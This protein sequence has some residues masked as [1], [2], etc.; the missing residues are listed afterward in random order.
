MSYDMPTSPSVVNPEIAKV[1]FTGVV[2]APVTAARRP[3]GDFAIPVSPKKAGNFA[4]VKAVGAFAAAGSAAG[5]KSAARRAPSMVSRAQ[6]EATRLGRPE[7]VPEDFV[8]NVA[9]PTRDQISASLRANNQ[10]LA[11]FAVPAAKEEDLDA[12]P[13]RHANAPRY[14]AL[15]GDRLAPLWTAKRR[16]MQGV[17]FVEG[18]EAVKP[19]TK[20]EMDAV[21]AAL[22]GA[23]KA[24]QDDAWEWANANV[25]GEGEDE[26][27]IDLD[28]ELPPMHIVLTNTGVG[29]SE[30]GS[31]RIRE[32]LMYRP[33]WPVRAIGGEDDGKVGWGHAPAVVAGPDYGLLGELERERLLATHDKQGQLLLTSRGDELEVAETGYY[34]GAERAGCRRMTERKIL[35]EAGL[36]SHKL[37]KQVVKEKETGEETV[38]ECPYAN[39]EEY[40]VCPVIAMRLRFSEDPLGRGFIVNG[41]LDKKDLDAEPGRLNNVPGVVLTPHAMS[42]KKGVPHNVKNPRYVVWDET[43]CGAMVAQTVMPMGALTM[44]RPAPKLTKK[45]RED[46]HQ[47]EFLLADRNNLGEA[48]T[49]ALLAGE[50]LADALMFYALVEDAWS[51]GYETITK[52]RRERRA[53]RQ[54]FDF[55]VVTAEQWDEVKRLLGT[56]KRVAWGAGNVDDL[57][58]HTLTENENEARIREIAA[59]PTAP[60]AHEEWRFY[61]ILE[62]RIEL[63]RKHHMLRNKIAALEGLAAAGNQHANVEQRLEKMKAKLAGEFRIA[64]ARD[65]RIALHPNGQDIELSWRN[66]FVWS[67]VPVLLLDASANR[68]LYEAVFGSK[69]RIVFHD[70]RTTE[71][72]RTVFVKHDACATGRLVE[73]QYD[74]VREVQV[75]DRDGNVVGTR[76]RDTKLEKANNRL[77]VKRAK[78]AIAKLHQGQAMLVTSTKKL[79]AEMETWADGDLDAVAAIERGL[80]DPFAVADVSQRFMHYGNLR[81]KDG[82][83]DFDVLVNVGKQELPDDVIRREARA[84]YYD[85][86]EEEGD[87]LPPRSAEEAG[88]PKTIVDRLHRMRDGRMVVIPTPI[89][90]NVWEAM[91]QEQKREEEISQALG[92]LRPFH[93]LVRGDHPSRWQVAYIIGNVA[94]V[95]IVLD[96]VISIDDLAA[97]TKLTEVAMTNGGVVSSRAWEAA[98]FVNARAKTREK[99]PETALN[100][101]I[102][103]AAKALRELGFGEDEQAT[104]PGWACVKVKSGK[105]GGGYAVFVDLGTVSEEDVCRAAVAHLAAFGIERPAEDAYVVRM[106]PLPNTPV[107]TFEDTRASRAERLEAVREAAEFVF[108][109]MT[110]ERD[111]FPAQ[112]ELF[113]H[114]RA[115]A[116]RAAAAPA[117]KRLPPRPPV[118]LG[119]DEKIEHDQAADRDERR[120]AFAQPDEVDEQIPW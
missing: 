36:S 69:F 111:E 39:H 33:L 31:R 67:K 117:P 52:M 116:T 38:Y 85:Q 35:A 108:C 2:A 17:R 10:R 60:Y 83:R 70:L 43:A 37:C 25:R 57:I 89:Y 118:G 114:Q 48:L 82:A 74:F 50:E 24:F 15:E 71:R 34:C 104:P 95:N 79:R 119:P 55:S 92:R 64:R 20:E 8:T 90:R 75:K 72:L 106:A 49:D 110:G 120:A 12:A 68:R 21:G 7:G 73:D 51:N 80:P 78:A 53:R 61:K 113:R 5:L 6:L 88:H 86:P 26:D 46:G 105:R 99:D 115:L 1:A 101:R 94:P 9:E 16:E 54:R 84:F 63:L 96:D 62:D 19:L 58:D 11:A 107:I 3:F 32:D 56:V 87:V 66:E 27:G 22:D 91:V 41:K 77:K 28:G 23:I 59:T 97:Q 18:G 14:E 30:R 13:S 45:E 76:V 44:V 65:V 103:A 98:G 47:A 109:E 81:G 29:K 100:N 42:D 4:P 112:V 40:G 93:K 102:K